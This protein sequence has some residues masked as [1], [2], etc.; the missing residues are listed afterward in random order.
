MNSFWEK[1]FG[2]I[3]SQIVKQDLSRAGSSSDAKIATFS[4]PIA[5]TG[6]D[7]MSEEVNTRLNIVGFMRTQIGKPYR[8]GA[9]I[10]Q[11]FEKDADDWDCS[12]ITEGSYRSF[13]KF[14]PD[15]AQQ[16]YDFCQS[17]NKSM[18]GDLGFLWSDKRGK[19]GHV[20]M[21]TDVEDPVS[22]WDSI[23]RWRGIRRHPDF[24]RPPADRV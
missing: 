14:L 21:Y 2:F 5:A 9:E 22:M 11:G 12:E 18:P 6:Y 17:V 7:T 23:P 3:S 20:M 24:A 16:Q 8:L 13:G 19:I 1:I 15:G 4:M 10:L